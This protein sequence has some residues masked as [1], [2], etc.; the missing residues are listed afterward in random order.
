ME[1]IAILQ[2]QFYKTLIKRHTQKILYLLLFIYL[3]INMQKMAIASFLFIL[4]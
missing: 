4:G 3:S 2:K 1:K